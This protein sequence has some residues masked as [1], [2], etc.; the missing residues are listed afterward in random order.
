VAGAYG[1]FAEIIAS[2][3]QDASPEEIGETIGKR[4]GILARIAPV[5]HERL[6]GIAEPV[7]LDKEEERF[8]LFDAVAQFFLSASRRAPVVLILDDLHWADR[9][10]VALLNHVSRFT[11]GNPI[12]LIGAYRDAEVGRTHPLSTALTGLARNPNCETITLIGLQSDELASLLK[13]IGDAEAPPGAGHGFPGSDR[14]QSAVLSRTA[15][16]SG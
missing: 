1:P 3:A 15:P 6:E 2:Y 7:S 13:L 4:A 14:G 10:T 11:S 12:L 5:L 16:A 8:R 9:G